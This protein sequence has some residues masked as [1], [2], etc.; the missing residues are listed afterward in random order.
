MHFTS[1]LSFVT[2]ALSLSGTLAA[3]LSVAPGSE[4]YAGVARTPLEAGPDFQLPNSVFMPRPP[5]CDNGT[6]T[7]IECAL[8]LK[9]E[10]IEAAPGSVYSPIDCGDGIPGAMC[11]KKR[12]PIEAEPR[13]VPSI[14]GVITLQPTSCTGGFGNGTVFTVPC[15]DLGFQEVKR[16]LIENL[17][18]SDIQTILDKLQNHKRRGFF[19]SKFPVYPEGTLLPQGGAD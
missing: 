11:S 3:P 2:L 5:G 4:M 12:E 13:S 17:S 15:G 1:P 7:G 18:P 10:P 19:H 6:V 9:R 16:S 8:E 14:P